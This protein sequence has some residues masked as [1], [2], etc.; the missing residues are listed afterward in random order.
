MGGSMKKDRYLTWTNYLVSGTVITVL[1]II[2]IV[3]GVNLYRWTITILGLGFLG[4]VLADLMKNVS[5]KK[6]SNS[7][8]SRILLNLTIAVVL[9]FFQ[10]V[11]MAVLPICF[12]LYLL[13][14]AAIKFVSYW[15]LKHDNVNK[16]YR[17]FVMGVI[18]LFGGILF[19]TSPI[20]NLSLLLTIIGIYFIL[21]GVSYYR[22]FI[23]ELIPRRYKNKLKR[24]FRMAQ[25]AFIDA[26]IPISVLNSLNRYVNNQDESKLDYELK[27]EDTSPDLEIFIHVADHGFNAFGHVDIYFEGK[28]ISYGNYDNTS[29]R[30][31]TSVGDGILVVTNKEEYI[32]FCIE[33]SKKTLIGF[34]LK[35]NEKQKE[36]VRKQINNLKS[37]TDPWYPKY[38]T[39]QTA[40]LDFSENTYQKDYASLLVMK[41]HAKLYKF[42]KGLYRH[43]FV[44]TNNCTYF[45]DSIIGKTGSD[46]LKMNGII[47]PG[48]YYDYLNYEFKRRGSMVIRKRIYNAQSEGIVLQEKKSKLPFKLSS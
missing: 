24:K 12:G 33:H 26:F 36:N 2:A 22:S 11:A 28:V 17:E 44:L 43:Y 25:P 45:A 4:L 21:I 37:N 19:I 8:W 46:I 42:K 3:G 34:G 48:T 27:K 32:P 41:T 7:R 18:F 20:N 14:N 6:K 39:D 38:V 47:T 29:F 1:G 23:A 35:L 16:R 40:G 31:F 30:L 13:I 9:L 5:S 10:K 15:I